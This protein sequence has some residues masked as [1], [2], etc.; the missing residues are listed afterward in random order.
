MLSSQN[1][2][3]TAS[4]PFVLF[5]PFV[6]VWHWMF[7]PTQAHADRQSHT[8]RTVGVVAIIVFCLSLVV[9]TVLNGKKWYDIYQTWQSNRLIK[10]A[11]SFESQDRILEA[12]INA[13]EAYSLDPENPNAIRTLARYYTASKQKEALHLI[14]KLQDKG[15]MTDEDTLMHI[16]ALSNAYENKEAQTKIEEV[17]RNS[18]A[19][20][21]MVEIA[22]HVM[23]RLGRREQLLEILRGYMQQ[24]PDDLESKL[25]LAKREVEFG[26]EGDP[27]AGMQKLWEIAQDQGKS[28]LRA[29]E[30]LDGLKL[31]EPE[32]QRLVERLEAHPLAQQAHKVAALRRMASMHPEKRTQIIEK[33]VEDRRNASREDLVPLAAWLVKDGEHERL[34]RFLKPEVVQDFAPL[35]GHYLNA[36][37]LA[38][39]YDEM[40]KMVRDPV[41]RLTTAER[42]FY[43]VHLAYVQKKSW[44]EVNALLVDALTAMQGAA[45]PD[46]VLQIAIWAE[47]RDHLLVAEQAYRAA[48][49][50]SG[51]EQVQRQGHEGLLRLTYRNGNSK[52]FM[53]AARDTA[54]RWP[55]N[56]HFLERSL[57]ASL[58]AGIEIEL[59]V[60]RVQKLLAARPDDT[61]R[62]LLSAL[63]HYRM[64]DPKAALQQLRS[65]NLNELSLGQGAVLSGILRAAGAQRESG[66]VAGQ[67]PQDAVM[68][69]EEKQFLTQARS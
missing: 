50:T 7:P 66:T 30:F 24:S 3:P 52:G 15:L 8:A 44:E 23:Q 48:A 9:V 56:Q 4:R 38:Q 6:A 13:N 37:M 34:L 17:L 64:L 11:G 45:S 63:A 41:T 46:R 39:R 33:A 60:M 22:D 61:Q 68:L 16:Q 53:E 20:P 67:I 28:G 35:L 14:K 18:K 54:R 25:I 65:I 43:L 5:R 29:L 32:Q 19:S 10:K 31:S 36:L 2:N 1:P 49:N 59:T 55:D 40:E 62:R 21:R 69:P 57:Y 12:W 42:S 51:S 26:A 58:L 47:Q 27:A